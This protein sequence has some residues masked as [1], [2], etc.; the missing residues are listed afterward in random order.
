MSF[1]RTPATG[2]FGAIGTVVSAGPVTLPKKSG[3]TFT[4]YV[5]VLNTGVELDYGFK[6]PGLRVGD[7][8]NVS[9][10]KEYGTY[11]VTGGS[12][13]GAGLPPA[14]PIAPRSPPAP[15][16]RPSAPSSGGFSNGRVFP[17][18]REHGDTAI[19]R[20]NALTNAVKT[21]TDGGLTIPLDDQASWDA[22]TDRVIQVAYKY[23]AFSAGHLDGELIERL[24]KKTEK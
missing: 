9:V 10:M 5:A 6:D 19:L 3:G 21:V 11:K 7:T 20:Q 15:G 13:S 8:I 18:P 16:A 12:G 14:M 2:P 23:S 24:A 22:L 4:K 17:V 1:A